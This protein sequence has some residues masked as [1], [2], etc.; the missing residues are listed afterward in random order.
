MCHVYPVHNCVKG[1]RGNLFK[2]PYTLHD[3]KLHPSLLGTKF[4]PQPKTHFVEVL[5]VIMILTSCYVHFY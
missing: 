5:F 1:L 3:N 2:L 4:R